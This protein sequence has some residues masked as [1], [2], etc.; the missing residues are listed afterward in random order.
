MRFEFSGALYR[1]AN[2]NREVEAQGSTLGE[3]LDHL[4]EQYPPLGNTML[5]TTGQ[6]SGSHRLF[7]N[8]EQ[9]TALRDLLDAAEPNEVHR[10]MSASTALE[11]AR[12]VITHFSILRPTALL[13]TKLD[14]TKRYGPL[15]CLTA[16]AGLPLSYFSIGQSVPDDIMPASPGAVAKLVV[17]GGDDRGATSS[18]SS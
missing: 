10:L 15:F 17:E 16:E 8:G 2:Y 6:V 18:E 4:I 7:L 1:F 9:M 5:D 11:D 14:E 13:F 12:D 3:C